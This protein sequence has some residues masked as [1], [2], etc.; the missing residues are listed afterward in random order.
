MIMNKF[1]MSLRASKLDEFYDAAIQLRA[2]LLTDG[3]IKDRTYH[4]KKYKQCFK[5][6]DLVSYLVDTGECK[7]RSEAIMVG[8]SLLMFGMIHHVV[9]D[10]LF[11]DKPLFYRFRMD[12][13]TYQ[14]SSREYRL[15]CRKAVHIHAA[16]H[17]SGIMIKDRE[18]G[19]RVFKRCFVPRE[20]IPW[21]MAQELAKD[22]GDAIKIGKDLTKH[23]F[24]HH[25]CDDHEFKDEY[26][27]FRFRWDEL[28]SSDAFEEFISTTQGGLFMG[29]VNPALRLVV[30]K[31]R[32]ILLRKSI[33]GKMDVH[34][35]DQ[36]ILQDVTIMD[37]EQTSSKEELVDMAQTDMS[38]MS[39][40]GDFKLKMAQPDKEDSPT[41]TMKRDRIAVIQTLAH[42]FT[43]IREQVAVQPWYHGKLSREET[44]E[45]LIAAG[46]VNG[47]WL[48]R[49]SSTLQNQYVLSLC[50]EGEVYHLRINAWGWRKT[51][52]HNNE[53]G[54]TF[55]IDNGQHCGSIEELVEF[56]KKNARELPTALTSPC[57]RP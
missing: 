48:V 7:T 43:Q 10:H 55:N 20:F 28:D 36:D 31:V 52:L 17:I 26:L 44:V 2:T 54:F 9:D 37:E 15:L 8:C 21:L 41:P 3:I 11:A 6:D 16:M 24:I 32:K 42:E 40:D 51:T 25:V 35:S 13:D 27:F 30:P 1:T 23:G 56:Y 4:L 34:V 38:N 29:H 45:R 5:G 12:D 50:F 14:A 19:S 39:L 22:Q 18:Y 46:G 49:D 33:M 53:P 57:L 47:L